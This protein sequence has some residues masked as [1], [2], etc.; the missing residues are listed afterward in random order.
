MI[1]FDRIRA[2]LEKSSKDFGLP[3]TN[4]TSQEGKQPAS[5][6]TDGSPFIFPISGWSSGYVNILER[7]FRIQRTFIYEYLVDHLS[8]AVPTKNFRALKTG[9]NLFS[10]GHVQ[11]I[12]MIVDA[13]FCYYKG[14]VLPSMKK[15]IIYTVL[16]AIQLSSKSIYCVKCSCPAAESQSCVHL[17][18]VLH[19]LESLFATAQSGV[20]TLAGLA[21]GES[22]TS[23]ECSWLK[24]RMRKVPATRADN[25][26][27]M[28]HEYGKERKRKRT[29]IDFDPRPPSKRTDSTIEAAKNILLSGLKGTGTCAELMLQ[30]N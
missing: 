11:S 2:Y 21:V 17:S 7:G 1:F 22:K 24:P 10:S 28:K 27:Y 29:Q 30:Y 23:F 6:S 8:C 16:C 18:A 4:S 26:H 12:Q 5:I 9:Y 14:A 25:I 13:S 19:A 3:T 15:G 20:A